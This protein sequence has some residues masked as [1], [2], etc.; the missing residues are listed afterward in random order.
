MS[1]RMADLLCGLVGG[2]SRLEQASGHSI[3]SPSRPLQ[4]TVCY[5]R[6]A[7]GKAIVK[8]SIWRFA[9]LLD[10]T[11]SWTS[12]DAGCLKSRIGRTACAE[13][14]LRSLEA[15][16]TLATSQNAFTSQGGGGA[17]AESTGAATRPAGQDSSVTPLQRQQVSNSVKT[18]AGGQSQNAT[19]GA[20]V[21]GEGLQKYNGEAV[22]SLDDKPPSAKRKSR[23]KRSAGSKPARPKTRTWNAPARED[24]VLPNP[25]G[26]LTSTLRKQRL[27]KR[28]AQLGTGSVGS[29]L[30]HRRK[31][32]ADSADQEDR[33]LTRTVVALARKRQLRKIFDVL[34]EASARGQAP[35]LVTMNAA[36][37]ACTRC[38]AVDTAL[39]L[40]A[41]MDA[42]GGCG[43]DAVSYGTLIKGL[44]A[45]GRLDEA[46]QMVEAMENAW[47]Q[48][49]SR[50]TQGAMRSSGPGG[51]PVAP[52]EPTRITSLMLLDACAE[53]G[54]ASR[55]RAVALR[56]RGLFGTDRV[57]YTT[58]I[59]AY[60]RS[61]RPLDALA[62]RKEMEVA[63]YPP[64]RLA[65]NMF[66]LAAVRGN[67]LGT[68]L[69]LLREMEERAQAKG[70]DA[71]R[72]DV[73]TYSTLLKIVDEVE[74][75]EPQMPVDMVKDIILRMEACGRAE[76]LAQSTDG[77]SP[78]ADSEG[79]GNEA[80]ASELVP[81]A[82]ASQGKRQGGARGS[83][84]VR[85]H[86]ADRIAYTAA[87]HALCKVG[88]LQ[89][90]LDLLR[91]LE[92]MAEADPDMRPRP[93]AYLSVMRAA[94]EA[95]DLPG[96]QALLAEMRQRCGGRIS[97]DDRVLADDLLVTAAV[98]AGDEAAARRL[99]ADAEQMR[100]GL[101]LNARM[102]KALVKL[103]VTKGT[104]NLNG[105][106]PLVFRKETKI[107]SLVEAAMRPVDSFPVLKSSQKV[108]DVVLRLW[109]QAAL[110]VV[111][112][113][114]GVYLGLI[115]RACCTDLQ[116]T[117]YE[118][119]LS[120][121]RTVATSVPTGVRVVDAAELMVGANLEIVA[122]L[123]PKKQVLVGVLTKEDLFEPLELLSVDPPEAGKADESL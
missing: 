9:S 53:S 82:P 116:Q 120:K 13:L 44:G 66:I 55:A 32:A 20:S 50:R 101:T 67:D 84:G 86:G 35:N 94:A 52:P 15:G 40:F 99:I 89:D 108:K 105:Y 74:E 59:K 97:K 81:S 54:D 93:V 115:T 113:G 6:D 21:N 109:R 56:I 75:D 29:Q 22:L 64:D 106:I 57:L 16:P 5:A 45:A 87:I 79:A 3:A 111:E 23:K 78:R 30:F 39:D 11:N 112:D 2:G 47:R 69:G 31:W 77:T 1:C 8:T 43:I 24:R 104:R 85:Q 36:L 95:G 107:F 118:A 65:Y 92:R 42:P 62:L 19:N 33:A 91:Q 48:Y 119:M 10:S 14:T 63:G 58:L 34:D 121:P 103:S 46:F 18:G 7:R 102:Y 122:V 37:A 61:P 90:G 26:V 71:L 100:G 110:P 88:A 17:V 41:E 123:E 117:V 70:D 49:R 27:E 4:R 38:G 25:G 76:A 96:T 68:A 80:G 12:R 73:V 28:Q 72:P 51:R 60:A 98:N 83:R 114:T